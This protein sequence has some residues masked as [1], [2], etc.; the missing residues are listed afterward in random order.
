MSL[1]NSV[2]TR[3]TLYVAIAGLTAL[4]SDLNS[5]KDGANTFEIFS[6]FCNC[7]LQCLIAWRAFIDQSISNQNNNLSSTN[8]PSVGKLQVGGINSLSDE[9]EK[10]ALEV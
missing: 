3:W 9:V 2:G 8:Q 7:S 5:L 4:T 6:L 1:I 10:K